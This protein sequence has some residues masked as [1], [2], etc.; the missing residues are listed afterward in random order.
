M[1]K[2]QISDDEFAVSG[3]RDGSV[4][5]WR[6]QDQPDDAQPCSHVPWVRMPTSAHT[7]WNVYGPNHSWNYPTTR[8]ITT[9]RLG[10]QFDRVRTLVFSQRSRSIT[11][12]SL[13]SHMCVVDSETFQKVYHYF[14]CEQLKEILKQKSQLNYPVTRS[15]LSISFPT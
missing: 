6:F 9:R 10:Q 8:P 3:S 1:E 13:S 2:W 11:C 15:V 4:A 14:S 7:A 12:A 5:L